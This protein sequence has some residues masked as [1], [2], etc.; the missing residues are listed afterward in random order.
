LRAFPIVQF[1]LPLAASAAVFPI[2][3]SATRIG[4]AKQVGAL[5][6]G[7]RSAFDEIGREHWAKFATTV[8]L[9]PPLV[10]DRLATMAAELPRHAAAVLA[11]DPT[12]AGEPLIGRILELLTTRCRRVAEDFAGR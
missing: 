3:T 10:R 9:S 5:K 8:G 1:S 2:V 11:A 6:I 4:S 7:S 12:L